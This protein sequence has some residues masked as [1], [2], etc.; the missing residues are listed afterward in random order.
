MATFLSFRFN[1]SNLGMISSQYVGNSPSNQVAAPAIRKSY[2]SKSFCHASSMETSSTVSS[3]K[4]SCI[5]LATAAVLCVLVPQNNPIFF[6]F[7]MLIIQVP[8]YKFVLR[9]EESL[10]RGWYENR[11]V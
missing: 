7:N 4:A 9:S 3:P 1:V 10:F 5:F 6:I 8:L 2:D 11:R